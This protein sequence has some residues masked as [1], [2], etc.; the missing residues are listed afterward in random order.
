MTTTSST[1]SEYP[2]Y[3]AICAAIRLKASKYSMRNMRIY[4][5]PQDWKRLFVEVPELIDI[6]IDGRRAVKM[7]KVENFWIEINIDW[8][9]RGGEVWTYEQGSGEDVARG[10][11]M[12]NSEWH[13]GR[14]GGK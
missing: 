13:M 2:L 7:L 11:Q 8:E 4:L 1:S 6:V 9:L 3:E 5:G 14:S 10:R 12:A